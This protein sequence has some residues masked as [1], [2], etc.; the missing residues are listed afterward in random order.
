VTI[1]LAPE[2]ARGELM[3]LVV[4]EQKHL[5]HRGRVHLYEATIVRRQGNRRTLGVIESQYIGQ[6]IPTTWWSPT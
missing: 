5:F 4:H 1:T 6:N 3:Q 2:L